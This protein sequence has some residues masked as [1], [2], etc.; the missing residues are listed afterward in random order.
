MAAIMAEITSWVQALIT[1]FVDS[2]TSIMAL[3]YKPMETGGGELTVIGSLA[4]LGLAFAIVRW[5]I[6]FITR[7]FVK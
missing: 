3:F 5:S 6:K 7:F 1:M 2:V 4:L